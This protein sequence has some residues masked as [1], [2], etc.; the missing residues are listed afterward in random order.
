M[1]KN[2]GGGETATDNVERKEALLRKKLKLAEKRD[3]VVI[4]PC[5]KPKRFAMVNMLLQLD[6]IVRTIKQRSNYRLSRDDVEDLMTEVMAFVDSLWSEMTAMAPYNLGLRKE[7]WRWIN[8]PVDARLKKARI[9]VAFVFVPSSR[10]TGQAAMAVKVIEKRIDE[11]RWS[12]N[13]FDRLK[14]AAQRYERIRADFDSVLQRLS[15][16]LGIK[17]RPFKS[18]DTKN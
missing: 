17:Y 6:R 7:E 5:V 3:S 10:E 8:D 13:T 18:D 9:P 2:E 1:K 16:S 14:E 11:L 15:E 12:L 4:I